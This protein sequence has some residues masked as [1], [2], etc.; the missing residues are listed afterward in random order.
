MQT[1]K[2]KIRTVPKISSGI[3]NP[4]PNKQERPDRTEKLE[5]QERFDKLDRTDR[6]ERRSKIVKLRLPP[7]KLAALALPPEQRSYRLTAALNPSL[8]RKAEGAPEGDRVSFK[9]ASVNGYNNSIK[10][11]DSLIVKLRLGREKCLRIRERYRA[12]Q[13][14]A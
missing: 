13:D 4:K 3:K 12:R 14:G 2:I 8:K 9:K 10:E 11:R 5:R 7:S 1:S 6:P